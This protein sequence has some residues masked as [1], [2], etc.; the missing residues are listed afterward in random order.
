MNDVIFFFLYNF[1]HKSAIFDWL[2][3]FTADI[4]PYIVIILAGLFLLFHHEIFKA[5]NPWQDFLQKKKEIILVF[6]TSGFAWVIARLLKL[7]I[8]TPRPFVEFSNVQAL[9][10]ETGF[11]FPSGHATFFT[12][13]AV[14]IFFYHKKVGYIFMLFALLI[15]LA[16]VI[17]GV[18]FPIDIL[19]GIVLGALIAYFFKNI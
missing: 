9:L 2:V 14:A 15:S 3:I 4:F 8:H 12:A 16:R 13:L 6:I 11:A 10:S 18:H 19:G 7:I 1:S 17:S 5:E